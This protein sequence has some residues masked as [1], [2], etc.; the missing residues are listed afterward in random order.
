MHTTRATAELRT[1]E[2]DLH[3]LLRRAL[4]ED[5]GRGDVTTA[6]TVPK[7][8]RASGTFLAKSDLVVSGLDAARCAF[9]VLAD[10]AVEF[11]AYVE[12][13][14]AVRAGEPL[15]RVEGRAR[16]LLGAERVALNL[17]MRLCGVATLTRRYAEAVAGTDARVCDT[18]KTTPGLRTLEKAA[19]RA[20]GGVNHRFGL[21]DGILIKDNH[22]ALAGGIR[23]AVELA[24][25]GAPHL[26]K[27]EVEVESRDELLEALRAGADAV[28]LDN[29][30]PQEVRRCVEAAREPESPPVVIEVSGNV[31]LGNV[32]LYAEAGADLISVGA[33]THSAPAADISLDLR[34]QAGS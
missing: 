29:M 16:T 6:L 20:G 12:E 24:R 13:G 18:R 23:R 1:L 9:E 21:D 14:E 19:V 7:G 10:E 3:D 33:L 25:S 4:R 34:P 17:L 5:V 32:R 8:A 22:L 15:A 2:G 11:R 30:S 26:L 31:G 28:L 27:V